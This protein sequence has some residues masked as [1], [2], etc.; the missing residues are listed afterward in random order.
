M[1]ES[2]RKRSYA[3][4]RLDTR[5]YTP[6]EYGRW[7]REMRWVHRLWGEKQAL[8]DTL[9]A[10]V[11]EKRLTHA[12]IVDVGAGNGDVLGLIAEML[13]DIDL[14]LVAGE[15]SDDALDA[16]A[17]DRSKRT[18]SPVKCSGLDL[19]FD[20][21]SIDYAVSTLTLHHLS[22]EG[23]IALIREM[24][25]VTRRRF[26]VVDLNRH[27]VG[28][29]AWKLFSPLV[30][31]RFT[32]EDGA[33]SIFRSFTAG[34]LLALAKKAGVSEVKVSHSRANRLVLSGR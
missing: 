33:L 24:C 30:F 1:F 10:D 17:S 8:R 15:T 21:H 2:F 34:E 16:L 9:V 5:D 18:L 25:R 29:Y 31:Q 22:D 26:Y 28:Y 23:A 13:P 27:P 14:F 7:L 12:S 32:Q 11:R 20:D 19:P 3:L 4:E 6:A